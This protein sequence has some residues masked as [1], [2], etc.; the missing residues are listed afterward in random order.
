MQAYTEESRVKTATAEYG[1][2]NEQRKLTL[3]N[4]N[5]MFT[6]RLSTTSRMTELELT[7]EE[8][9]DLSSFAVAML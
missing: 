5:G 8:V 7:P 6:I 9:A 3:T 2:G 4:D 1:Y